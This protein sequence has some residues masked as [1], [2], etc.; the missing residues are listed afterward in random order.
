LAKLVPRRAE[1]AS[2]VRRIVDDFV[3]EVRA[4]G[5]PWERRFAEKFGIVLAAAILMSEFEIGPWTEE[6]ARDAITAIY[7]TARGSS[8]SPDESAEAFVQKLRKLLKR[9][10]RFPK[11]GKKGQKLS[12]KAV[13]ASWGVLKKDAKAGWLVLIPYSRVERLVKPPAMTR[14]VLRALAARNLVLEA[15]NANFTKQ[16]MLKSLTGST[17]QG[18]VRFPRKKIMTHSYVTH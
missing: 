4:G 16:V 10:K 15:R 2:R 13:A 14:P 11:V 8:V 5:E 9:G 1:F 18:F 17:R 6:R 12:S 7:G 3:N